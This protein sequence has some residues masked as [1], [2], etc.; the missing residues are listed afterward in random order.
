MS[1]NVVLVLAFA[2]MSL[3]FCSCRSTDSGSASSQWNDS[4]PKT[5]EYP[6]QPGANN[7]ERQGKTYEFVGKVSQV[8][9]LSQYDQRVLLVDLDPGFVVVV[10]EVQVSTGSPPQVEG[11]TIALGIHSL[12]RLFGSEGESIVGKRYL[13]S[14][15]RDPAARTFWL[16]VECAAAPPH[17]KVIGPQIDDNH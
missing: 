10:T 14:M 4:G 7:R 8:S 9:L 12:V 11:G 16:E 17:E 15:W 13:F 5:P 6:G 1:N 2:F 3:L